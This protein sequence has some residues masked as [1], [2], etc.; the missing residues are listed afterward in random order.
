MTTR[1][2]T[3]SLSVSD[4][5]ALRWWADLAG[6]YQVNRSLESDV[7]GDLSSATGTAGIRHQPL[8]WMEV[9]LSGTGF[10]QS[11]NGTLGTDLTR[12][13]AFLGITLSKT[14]NIY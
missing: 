3:V 8:E 2:E 5:F 14:Y 13:S 4:Q 11:G 7:S 10:R 1:R 6:T 12:Y 9:H